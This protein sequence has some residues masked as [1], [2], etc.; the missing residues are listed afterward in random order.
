M[1]C[2]STPARPG[3]FPCP[4][5]HHYHCIVLEG[6]IDEAG[7]FITCLLK[8]PQGSSRFS[9]DGCYSCL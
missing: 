9:G 1:P 7:F 2:P 5:P 4:N 3:V 6:E 8:I